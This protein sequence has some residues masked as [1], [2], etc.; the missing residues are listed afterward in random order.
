M[1]DFVSITIQDDQVQ[2]VLRRLETSVADMTPA[3][4]A[5]AASLA[6][7]TE[8]NFEAE[9]RPSWTPS[10]R[11]SR[12]GGVTLQDRGQLAASVVTDHD[13][14]SSVIGSNLP[15]ARIQHLGGQAGR[16]EAVELEPRPYLP[17]TEDG[18]LQPEAGEAVIGAVMRH[19]Q[20]AAAG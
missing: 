19:L 8:E 1:S 10:Q 6:F 16:N 14:H 20:H 2:R 4:R 13:P 15:Y 7:I 3:M 12:D 17:M 5:I 11:A 18:E 9:G